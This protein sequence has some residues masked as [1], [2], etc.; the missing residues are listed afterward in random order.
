MTFKTKCPNC[1][2]NFGRACSQALR[3]GQDVF[4][5]GK[6]FCFYHMFETN[7]SEHSKIWGAQKHLGIT[8][9]EFHSC[10]R[11]RAGP[12]PEG[13]LLGAFMFL[14]GG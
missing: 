6:D 5:E 9:S 14:Q 11:A 12:S 13:L 4:L 10:L 1:R 3:F 8:A 2:H 7:F